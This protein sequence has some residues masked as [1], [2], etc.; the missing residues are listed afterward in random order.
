MRRSRC[1][2]CR[3]FRDLGSPHAHRSRCRRLSL[4]IGPF[5]PPR[6]GGRRWFSS[7]SRV[8][9]ESTTPPSRRSTNAAPRTLCRPGVPDADLVGKAGHPTCADAR[10]DRE[11]VVGGKVLRQVKFDT[12]SV[13]DDGDGRRGRLGRGDPGSVRAQPDDWCRVSEV[14]HIVTSGRPGPAQRSR[15]GTRRDR[16]ATAD[17]PPPEV[18]GHPDTGASTGADTGAAEAGSSPAAGGALG[19]EVGKVAGTEDSTR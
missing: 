7:Y 17:R 14:A 12:R 13:D 9:R 15:K 18:V 8:E 3:R 1:G 10:R 19:K 16:H 2:D 11:V 5:D 4:D 6:Q